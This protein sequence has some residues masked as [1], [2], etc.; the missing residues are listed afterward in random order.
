MTFQLMSVNFVV[1]CD[2]MPGRAVVIPIAPINA[3]I[4]ITTGGTPTGGKI[5]PV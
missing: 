1:S 3:I 5:T 4:A 2:N